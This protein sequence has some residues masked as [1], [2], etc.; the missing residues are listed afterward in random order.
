[1]K[2]VLRLATSVLLLVLMF[3]PS[4]AMGQF[5]APVNPLINEKAPDFTLKTV[6][7]EEGNLTK[8]RDGK[9][10]I[11][12]FWATWCPHC[13]TQLKDLNNRSAEFEQKG[14]KVILVDVEEDAKQVASHLKKNK[15]AMDV[16]L[17]AEAKTSDEYSL[18]G[19]PTF[20]FIDKEGTVRAVEHSLPANYEEIL[21]NTTQAQPK[22]E[23][24]L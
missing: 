3:S 13:R 20:F 23:Q 9:S 24:A 17:D 16:W 1:M 6:N 4:Q 8:Y 21:G 10:A 7:G 14:I 22:A 11:V 19:V 15:I 2:S 5:F 12:F 18:I